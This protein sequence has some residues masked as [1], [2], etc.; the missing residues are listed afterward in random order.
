MMNE[1]FRKDK[2]PEQTKNL[3]LIIKDLALDKKKAIEALWS[4]NYF[5]YN[6]YSM[7]NLLEYIE[8]WDKSL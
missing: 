1:A 7:L 5:S 3:F 6:R 2:N 4:S 8:C